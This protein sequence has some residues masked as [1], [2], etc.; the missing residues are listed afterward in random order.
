[1][2]LPNL[3]SW[4]SGLDARKS[5]EYPGFN[6]SRGLYFFIYFLK[7]LLLCNSFLFL[8]RKIRNRR[9]AQLCARKKESKQIINKS[10]EEEEE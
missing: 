10:K 8:K 2:A 5:R 9:I 3:P 7:F 1:V 4:R 6:P